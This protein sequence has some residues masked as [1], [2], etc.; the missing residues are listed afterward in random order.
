VKNFR[1]PWAALLAALLLVAGP[2]LGANPIQQQHVTFLANYD[3]S[4]AT[5]FYCNYQGEDGDPWGGGTK[6]LTRIKTVGTSTTISSFVTSQGAFRGIDVGD[7][8]LI[9][10]PQPG[11]EVERVVITNA[12]DDTVTVDTSINL[13]A[14]GG[15]TYRWK[16]RVCDDSAFTTGQFDV[17]KFQDGI[18]LQV[19]VGTIAATSVDFALDC[20]IDRVGQGWNQVFTKAITAATYPGYTDEFFNTTPYD[21]CRVGIKVTGDVGAQ[22]A[23]VAI[24]PIHRGT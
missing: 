10:T 9:S 13:S 21:Y 1:K 7:L 18:L 3:V 2:V 17:T 6:R 22:A 24:R 11:G 15:Y 12:D 23:Y 5:Y 16:K 14:A 20:R 8:L 4:S 19:S